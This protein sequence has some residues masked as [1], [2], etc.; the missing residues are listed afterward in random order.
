M[1][2]FKQETEAWKF[3]DAACEARYQGNEFPYPY[4]LQNRADVIALCEWIETQAIRS[5]LEIGI[6]SGKLVS[7]LHSL[8]Q[9]EKLAVC[10]L[11]D[12]DKFGVEIKVPPETLCFWGDSCSNDYMNWRKN[13]GE[14]DLVL[15]DGAHSLEAV[16]ADFEINRH[17]PT[18]YL[19]FH[20]IGNPR[21]PDIVRFW[22]AL[23]GEKWSFCQPFS[24]PELQDLAPMGIGVWKVPL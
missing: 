9:F 4:I 20:D 12:A 5:Y 6:W 2:D 14:I 10:D 15:I 24:E 7:L 18:R 11:R 19:A 3:W 17:Y 21:T 13:L 8:F 23:P 1:R 16:M 22:N